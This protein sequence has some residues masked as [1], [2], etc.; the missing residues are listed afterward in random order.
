MSSQQ[1]LHQLLRKVTESSLSQHSPPFRATGCNLVVSEKLRALR[2]PW[3]T[4]HVPPFG[5]YSKCMG[6]LFAR[7][8]ETKRQVTK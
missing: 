7:S 2:P 4:K 1:W 6:T 5:W 3:H 8:R